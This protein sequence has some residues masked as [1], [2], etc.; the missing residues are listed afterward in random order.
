MLYRAA[1]IRLQKGKL[2]LTFSTFFFFKIRNCTFRIFSA[3]KAVKPVIEE[4]S[5]K[6]YKLPL[7]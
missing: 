7:S 5:E 6:Y 1:K 3:S 2:L 4:I